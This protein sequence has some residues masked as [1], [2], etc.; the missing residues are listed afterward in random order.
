MRLIKFAAH[1]RHSP[2]DNRAHSQ[3]SA[4]FIP[5]SLTFP[6]TRCWWSQRISAIEQSDGRRS[7]TY[8]GAEEIASI[9]NEVGENAE[10]VEAG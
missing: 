5:P 3:P 1:Y 9:E 4:L 7:E 10:R 6:K 2:S 8:D